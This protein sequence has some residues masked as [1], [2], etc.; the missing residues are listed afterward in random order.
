[1]NQDKIKEFIKTSRIKS[2]LSQEKFGQKYGVTYQA[3]SKWETGK[4]LPDISIL[5]KICEDYNKDIN[6]LLS[7][8]I[9]K[10]RKYFFFTI[11]I[12][13]ILVSLCLYMCFKEKKDDF[14]FKQI[15]TSCEEFDLFGSMAFNNNKTSIYIS[16]ITYCGVDKEM[17]YDKISCTLY[18]NEK[19]NKKVIDSYEV[20]NNITLEE[21]LKNVSF[22]IDEYSNNCQKYYQNGLILE[23]EA[24]SN[25]KTITYNIPLEFKENCVYPS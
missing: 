5:R 19:D 12:I 2:N 14:E 10:R 9:K 23:I 21:F 4:N 11:G 18:E 6:E 20:N 22:N 8:N 3:V 7:N 15:V 24:T 25:N 16:N 17:V 1:M 13:I